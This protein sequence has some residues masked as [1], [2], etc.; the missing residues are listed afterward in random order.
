MLNLL[1]T[2]LTLSALGALAALILF[3]V[4]QRFNVEED[5]R[6]DE[7]ESMLPGANCGGCGFAGCRGFATAAVEQDDISNLNCPAGG[8]DMMAEVAAYLGKVPAEVMPQ[9]ATLRCGGCLAKRP[10]TN[11]YD[12]AKSCSVISSLYV[13]E[14]GCAS[15]CVGLG[16]C[17]TSCKFD[18]IYINEETGLAEID[19]ELCVACG[20]CV[21]ACPKSLIELRKRWPKNRSIYVACSSKEK[22]AKVMKA[23]KVGCIGCSKCLKAC[24]FN[25]ITVE[26]NLAYIDHT[27]CKL[28]RKCVAECPTKAIAMVSFVQPAVTAEA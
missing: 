9:T 8:A 7:V 15:G 4:V 26:N 28:C 22:G 17:V 1:Y 20:A 25:A 11:L 24:P 10:K 18:A 14:T 21:T 12:G 23:C 13:G 16:D 27:T 19:A 2:I 5:P 3:Y 6:I